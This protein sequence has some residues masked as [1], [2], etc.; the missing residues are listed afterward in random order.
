MDYLKIYDSRETAGKE[1][2]EI[3]Q[4]LNL[5]TPYILAIL[6][7]GA[8]VACPIAD[9]LQI[10]VNPL[11]VKKL[12]APQNSEYGFG[13]VT[14]DGTKVLNT[15]AVSSLKLNEEDI[16]KIASGI[17]KEIQRRQKVFGG[18]EDKKI[19]E[20]D[21]IITDD[22]IATGY[23][24]IAGIETV[25]KRKPRSITAAVPVSSQGAFLKIKKLVDNIICP[26]VSDDYFFAVASYY[27]EWYDLSEER[28]KNILEEYRQKYPE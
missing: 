8:Q 10:P 4:K 15:K 22:G 2:A 1:L 26:V 27:R 9:K 21:V 13:A 17:V 12:P 16:Q 28:I 25:K 11:V 19:Y 6:R 5:K 23:S 20:A 14:E 24:F 7:G 18:L 3:I